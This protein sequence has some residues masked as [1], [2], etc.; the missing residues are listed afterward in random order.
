V[1]P[2]TGVICGRQVASPSVIEAPLPTELQKFLE[3]LD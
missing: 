3:K 2:D 1:G